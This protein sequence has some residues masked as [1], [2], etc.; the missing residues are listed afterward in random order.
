MSK[1][2]RGALLS[3]LASY[4]ANA[5]FGYLAATNR[6]SDADA[7]GGFRLCLDTEEKATYFGKQFVDLWAEYL[8]FNFNVGEHI[9]E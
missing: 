4:G 3:A 1:E 8:A 2:N 7:Y 6:S 9:T 5:G